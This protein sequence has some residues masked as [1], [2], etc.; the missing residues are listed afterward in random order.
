ME[1]FIRRH[2]A[3]VSGVLSGFDRVRVRGTLRLLSSVRGMMHFMTQS[4]VLLKQF[5]QLVERTTTQLKEAT[6][7]IAQKAGRPVHYVVSPNQNK[8]EIALKIARQDGVTEGLIAVLEC[9]ESCRSFEVYKDRA[10]KQLDLRYLPRKC[11]H[12]YFYFFHPTLGF[13]HARL[14]TWFPFTLHVCFNGREWLA[15]QMDRAGVGYLRRDNCFVQVADVTRAQRLLDR[16]LSTDWPKLMHGIAR[17]VH[18]SK[19]RLLASCPVDYY[20]SVEESEWATD[21]MFRSPQALSQRYPALIRHGMAHL[22]SRDVMR[23]LGRKLP[24]EGRLPA[25]F[26]GEVVSDLRERPEGMRIKHRLN[27]NAIKMYDKQGSVLRV[28]TTINDPYDMKVFRA[29][30][31]DEGGKKDWRPLRKGMADLHRR[32]E[33]SQHANQR[34]LDSMATVADSAPL[35]PLAEAVCRRTRWKGKGVRALNPLSEEDA[36]LLKAVH[37]GEFLIHGFRNRD[38]R[39]VLY[40]GESRDPAEARRRSA[41]VTRKLRLLRAHGLVHKLPHT[42]RYTVSPKGQ[43]TITALLAAREADTARLMKAG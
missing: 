38:L 20:W 36:Q 13:M 39:A 6:G 5:R 15:R 19:D 26:S 43:T 34:Y 37:R 17:H 2:Q 40:P 28:E 33:V 41:V 4:G 18:P 42:H 11:L 32:A 7:R 35:G 24:P 29:K 22:Q 31:G 23:F 8:E 3:D 30:E 27:R 14:Q 25:A 21:V 10:K 9:V 16:Q 12:Q 1:T